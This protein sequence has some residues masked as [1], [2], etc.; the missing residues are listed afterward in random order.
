M[1]TASVSFENVYAR[2]PERF[3]ARV[4]P[5]RVPNPGLI[6]LNVELARELGLDSA[7]LT[8]PAGVAMLAG[9]AVPEGAE[10]LAQAYSGHQFGH[11]VPV[12]GDGRAILLGEVAGAGGARFDIQL[13]GSGRTPF[14]RGGDGKAAIGPVLREYI[15]SEAMAALG[16]PTTRAL[17]AVTTGE[18]VLRETP[19]PGAILT[20]VAGSHTRI[21]TFQYFYSRND[22]DG[23]KELA[24]YAL[25]RHF[26]DAADSAEPCLALLERVVAGQ[27]ALI[28]KWMQLGF[29]HGVM[30]TD[31]MA[32][33]GDTIDY[34]PCAFMDV[35]HPDTVFSSIDRLGRY[36]WSNQPKIAEWNLLRFAETVLPLLSDNEDRAR[37]LALPVVEGFV[38]RFR[39]RYS[40]G[41]ARKLGLSS[42]GDREGAF[43]DSTLGILAEQKVDF[44]LFFRHLT[45]VAAG[46]SPEPLAALFA[47]RNRFDQWLA[48]WREMSDIGEHAQSPHVPAMQAANPVVIPRNHRVEAAIQHAQRNDYAP[49]HRLVDAVSNPFA[50]RPEFADL[51]APPKPEEIVRQT[52]CGT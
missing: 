7:W 49:F 41:F 43:I 10:P 34:G 6:R 32:I 30:N 50:D 19:L 21:G 33:S 1:P 9:N 35:F 28:A 14:S 20:R 46:E 29:I 22:R 52:F 48:S 26:P 24:D 37:A 42:A 16:V 17:A 3:F 23:L 36:A 38:P 5:E 13:K 11:W 15:V 31:N 25:A 2:L 47:S 44:S 51:E 18:E 8:S 27:A 40:E 4:A 45:R 39:Q 12:L